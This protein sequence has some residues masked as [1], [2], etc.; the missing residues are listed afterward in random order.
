ML[1]TV[2][3]ADATKREGG[4]GTNIVTFWYRSLELLVGDE[5]FG[6]GVDAWSLGCL[7]AE[8]SCRRPL[9]GERRAAHDT[10]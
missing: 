8:L 5:N 3:L 1:V 9:L 2:R 6:T 4:M 10:A 7:L